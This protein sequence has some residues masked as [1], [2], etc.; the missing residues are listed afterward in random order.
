MR[1][2]EGFALQHLVH[3]IELVHSATSILNVSE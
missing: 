1:P 2:F 3:K